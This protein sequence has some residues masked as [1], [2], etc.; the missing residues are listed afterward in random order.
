MPDETHG[1]PAP[2]WTLAGLVRAAAVAG[3]AMGVGAGLG[4]LIAHEPAPKPAG[5]EHEQPP[6]AGPAELALVTP[7]M[8]GSTLADFEIA[9]IQAVSAG[10]ALRVICGR[11][12]ATVTLDVGL[13]AAG[14]PTPPAVAGRYAIFYSIRGATSQEGE[15]LAVALAA[16][17]EQNEA[18]SI[19]PGMAPYRPSLARRHPVQP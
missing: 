15:R 17:L 2:G 8:P 11:G 16:I 1:G 14:G 10:G 7:L 12:D 6:P 19:P 18:A 3:I 9:E 5:V 13:V 4:Y